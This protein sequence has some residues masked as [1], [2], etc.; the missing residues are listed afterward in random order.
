MDIAHLERFAAYSSAREALAAIDRAATAWPRELA[1][2]AR[3]VATSIVTTTAEALDAAAP[4]VRRRTLLR[5]AICHALELAAI[6][7]IAAKHG[8]KLDE[9]LLMASRMLSIL[10]MSFHATAVAD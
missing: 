5:G 3:G 1:T 9:S 7:D 8:L 10:G 4:A 6:C 2:H